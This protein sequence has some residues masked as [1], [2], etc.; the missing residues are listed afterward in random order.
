M[1]SAFESTSIVF[2]G[3]QLFSLQESQPNPSYQLGEGVHERDGV[4][5]ASIIG[6]P[7]RDGSTVSVVSSIRSSPVPVVG[8]IVTGTITKI[9]KPQAYVSIIMIEDSPLPI[10]HEFPGV[11]RSQDVRQLDK[12]RVVISDCFRPG[13]IVRAEVISPPTSSAGYLLATFREN[14]GVIMAE[15]LKTGN[16]MTMASPLEMIDKKSGLKEPRKVALTAKT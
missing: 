6:K 7:I 13:D 5:Y 15:N 1:S 4:I 3:Q 2:P 8:T 9:S 14:L 10:G 12:D 11:I 16:L